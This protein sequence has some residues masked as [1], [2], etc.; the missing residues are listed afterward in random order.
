MHNRWTLSGNVNLFVIYRTLTFRSGRITG[1]SHLRLAVT[2][3]F[4]AANISDEEVLMDHALSQMRQGVISNTGLLCLD[5][6][7][8]HALWIRNPI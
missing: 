1:V 6:E 7:T 5:C 8:S 3:V 2:R 4:L